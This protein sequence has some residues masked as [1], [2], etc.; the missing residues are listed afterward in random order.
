[1]PRPLP[2]TVD[3]VAVAISILRIVEFIS[4]AT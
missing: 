3:T 1:L 4:S 2:A